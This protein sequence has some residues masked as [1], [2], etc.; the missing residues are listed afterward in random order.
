MDNQSLELKT[1]IEAAKK[2]A[3]TALTYYKHNP[4]IEIKTDK[5]PVTKAD[6]EA[7]EVIKGVILS[8]FPNAKFVGEE[9][10]GDINENQLKIHKK[11]LT[12]QNIL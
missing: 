1:A 2:A 7:E 6:K 3:E 5:T 12:F 4:H 9:S 10:G 8:K 11:Y